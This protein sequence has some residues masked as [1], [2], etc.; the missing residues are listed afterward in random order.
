VGCP[1]QGYKTAKKANSHMIKKHSKESV[2]LYDVDDAGSKQKSAGSKRERGGGGRRGRGSQSRRSSAES[3]DSGAASEEDGS[4]DIDEERGG[5]SDDD[6][7]EREASSDD[8]ADKD[9]R[10][11]SDNNDEEDKLQLSELSKLLNELCEPETERATK[12]LDWPWPVFKRAEYGKE[13]KLVETPDM[14][15]SIYSTSAKEKIGSIVKKLNVDGKQLLELTL[16]FNSSIEELDFN[17]VCDEN[18]LL[19]VDMKLIDKAQDENR[20][21]RR[22]I[23]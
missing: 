9:E 18:T 13:V 19:V 12:N 16:Y 17:S 3:S 21:K 11:D 2:L 6:A 20:A 8:D 15:L 4:E 7:V 5:S 14:V 23:N 10:Q 22:K 1:N